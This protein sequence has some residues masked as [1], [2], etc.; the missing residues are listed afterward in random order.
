MRA[1]SSILLILHA[2]ALTPHTSLISANALAPP[3]IPTP[4]PTPTPTAAIVAAGAASTITPAAQLSAGTAGN[5]VAPPNP[6]DD[7]A[8]GP[9]ITGVAAERFRQTT[10]WGCV[11]RGT[12]RHCG[13]HMPIIDAGA[14]R[15]AWSSG[16]GVRA[17]GAAGVVGLLVW[18]G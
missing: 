14:A 3:P 2:L 15:G 7:T 13:W 1:I 16:G 18:M 6:C 10:Y 8:G 4:T 5:G 11:T 12:Y 17:A 9:E